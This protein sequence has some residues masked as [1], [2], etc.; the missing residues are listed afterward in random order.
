MEYVER[1][2]IMNKTKLR[3]DLRKDYQIGVRLKETEYNQ[4]QALSKLSDL[5]M[6]SYSRQL[7]LEM[8]EEKIKELSEEDSVI[9]TQL[10]YDDV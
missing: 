5:S 8:L 6:S 7:L 9:F 4:I 10:M 1:S 2:R 3:A